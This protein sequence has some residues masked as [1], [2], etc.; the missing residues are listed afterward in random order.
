MIYLN[1][2]HIIKIARKYESKIFIGIVHKLYS[3]LNDRIKCY[4]FVHTGHI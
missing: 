1:S 3:E 4:Y 2:E